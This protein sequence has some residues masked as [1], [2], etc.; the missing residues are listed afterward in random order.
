[1]TATFLDAKVLSL[2]VLC[3]YYVCVLGGENGNSRL[4]S[5]PKQLGAG[6]EAVGHGTNT[7]D[8]LCST[9]YPSR[10]TI[11]GPEEN[12]YFFRAIAFLRAESG[13]GW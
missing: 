6:S 3:G 2:P 11:V 7:Y 13:C 10:P 8:L 4:G 12:S 1:M 5:G 9:S